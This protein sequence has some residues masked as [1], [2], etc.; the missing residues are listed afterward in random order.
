MSAS[1]RTVGLA[2]GVAATMA[3]SLLTMAGTAQ[4]KPDVIW[5]EPYVI[6]MVETA[7]GTSDIVRNSSSDADSAAIVTTAAGTIDVPKNSSSRVTLTNDN[8]V[9]IG[10]NLPE[11]GLVSKSKSTAGTVAYVDS[12]NPVAPALQPTTDGGVRALV[13]VRNAAAPRKFNF[14]LHVPTG[15]MVMANETNGFDIVKPANGA[16][17]DLKFTG[18]DGAVDPEINPRTEDVW[19]VVGHIDA[20]WAKD[21]NGLSVPTSYRME[22]DTLVQEFQPTPSTVF[23]VVADPKVSFGRGVYIKFNKSEAKSVARYADASA[24]VVAACQKAPS[25]V[26]NVP[27]RTICRGTLG[28]AASSIA[29]T[30]KD[31]ARSNRC[32]ELRV[33]YPSPIGI[34]IGH[35][36]WKAY[37]C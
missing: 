3:A 13:G 17:L 20:P 4:A 6:S 23:P 30:F 7:T 8:N 5:E 26:R 34:V 2:A 37:S 14:K 11:S 10:F 33:P 18:E 28:Y 1:T 15:A 9:Q 19:E 22:G 12:D 21:D 31:A 16:D 25:R 27:V 32:V 36:A 24:L 29:N 35:P